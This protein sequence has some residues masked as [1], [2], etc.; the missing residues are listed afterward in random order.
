MTLPF[1]IIQNFLENLK[2]DSRA[3]ASFKDVST[4]IVYVGQFN[5]LLF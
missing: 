4:Y 5:P 2:S 1:A 3:V